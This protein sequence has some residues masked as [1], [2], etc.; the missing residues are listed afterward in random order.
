MQNIFYF[1]LDLYESLPS[2]QNNEPYMKK[3]ALIVIPGI[4]AKSVG[5]AL[6]R[7][8]EAISNQQSVASVTKIPTPEKPNMQQLELS[9][10]DTDEKKILDVYEVFWGD[11]IQKNHSDEMPLWKKVVFGLELIFFWFFSP[12]W[13]ASYKNKWMFTGIAFSGLIIT[14]WYVSILGVFISAIESAEVTEKFMDIFNIS[15]D[16][17]KDQNDLIGKS[18]TRIFLISGIVIGLIPALLGMILKV[19]GFSMKFIKSQL[20]RDDVKNRIQAQMNAIIKDDSYQSIKIFAHSLGVVPVLD[21]LSSYNSVHGKKI[22]LIT[23][24][25]PVSFLANKTKLFREYAEKVS[26]NELVAEW[27]DYFSKQDWLCSYET[28]GNPG[29]R[30]FS[31][32]LHVDSS[33]ISRMSTAP[34]LAY[35]SHSTVVEKLIGGWEHEIA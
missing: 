28:L 32:A 29:D 18:T 4:D 24:G 21:Y 26:E 16:T 9:H 13:K 1:R 17:G 25:S 35:F 19:S 8:T 23:I 22:Q 15:V 20:V 14:F 12:I 33:W 30:I 27:A 7:T 2:L 5:F 3:E 10:S 34:H 31:S 6:Q 11:I